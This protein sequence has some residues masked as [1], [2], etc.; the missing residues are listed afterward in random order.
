MFKYTYKITGVKGD[1]IS[2]EFCSDGITI[3][4][5]AEK[6]SEASDRIRQYLTDNFLKCDRVELQKIEF[7]EKKK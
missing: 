6:I 3:E 4:I 7:V 1:V 5:K 2:T